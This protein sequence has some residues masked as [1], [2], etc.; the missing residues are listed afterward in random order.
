M[1]IAIATLG[2][3]VNHYESDALLRRLKAV[4]NVV[5]FKE[6]AD[7]Y[8]INT[9]G[10]TGEA[11]H[12]SRQLIYRC[13][14]QSPEARIVVIGC[15]AKLEP[16][17]LR[18]LGA[19]LLPSTIAT[20]DAV[21][22]ICPDKALSSDSLATTDGGRNAPRARARRYLKV[23]DGCDQFCSY[24][25]IPYARGGIKSRTA[26]A[27]VSEARQLEADGAAEIVLTGIH[28]GK[29]GQGL[30][31]EAGLTD[32]LRLVLKN[33]C[34]TRFRL[35]SLEPTE[36]TEELL[37]VMVADSRVAR[38]FHIPLQSGSDKILTAMNRPYNIRA[39][40][41]VVARITARLPGAALT[42]D[43]IVGFPG[44]SES[45]FQDS[46]DFCAKTGFSKVHV[47][48]YSDRPPA[49]SVLLDGK[50]PEKVKRARSLRAR[51]LAAGLRRTY[52]T[53][54]IGELTQVAVE[55][56]AGDYCMG[57]TDSYLPARFPCKN[58]A[59]GSLV[60]M[61]ARDVEDGALVGSL[62]DQ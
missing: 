19:D 11:A 59:I 21:S 43:L 25:V 38:H 44:E 6:E 1:R 49:K 17:A 4:A 20:E 28:L 61:V 54:Q 24:C 27:V 9:C 3:K 52:M 35:S 8:V 36:V 48:V 32:L 16:D 29:Y 39:Y 37:A 46:L 12:K 22:F 18:T 23:Q 62:A 26:S 14:R 53:K 13:K 60:F 40:A 55:S 41:E 56:V 15:Y 30:R 7:V 42:T 51:E 45:D 34:S 47:F 31:E 5:P 33:T 10:V 57:T 2:C 50:L 58:I